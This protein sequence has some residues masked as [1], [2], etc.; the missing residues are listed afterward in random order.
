MWGGGGGRLTP[1]LLITDDVNTTKICSV[2]Y[3]LDPGMYGSSLKDERH[4]SV[5][6]AGHVMVVPAGSL[7]GP[8]RG[9]W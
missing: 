7:P 4:A 8:P 9:R 5:G 2:R 1:A 6:L 3:V